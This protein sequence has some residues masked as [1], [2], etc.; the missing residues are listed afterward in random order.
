MNQRLAIIASDEG[1]GRGWRARYGRRNG[2]VFNS[3]DSRALADALRALAHDPEL[4]ARL[5]AA[6]ARDVQA[7][8]P[9][10]WARGF[11]A[12]LASLGVSRGRW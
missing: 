5:G 12:A 2:L 7:Y 4:R 10:A 9:A 6:G 8:T 1:R 11:S 3:A